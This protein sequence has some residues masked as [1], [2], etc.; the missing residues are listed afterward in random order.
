MSLKKIA[1]SGM[2]WTAAQQFSTQGVNFIVSIILA[3]ILLPDEFGLI[4]MIAVFIAIGS[5][6]YNSGLTQSLIR[7]KDPDQD[8]YSTVFWFNM[9]GSILLFLVMFCLAP[10]I[11]DFYNKEILKDIIRVYSLSFII[12]AFSAVQSTRLTKTFDFKAHL[13][14]SLPSTIVT[15]LTGIYM[16]YMGYGVWSLVFNNLAGA[17]CSSILF[18]IVSGWRPSF[19]FHKQKFRTHFKFGY[20]MTLSGLL[21]T[22]FDN[23]YIIVIG[24]FFSPSQVGYYTRADTLKQ[25]PVGNISTILNTVAYPLFAAIQDDDVRLKAVYKRIIKMV[26]FLVAPILVFMAVVAEPLF[27]FL[28]TEKW[29]PA[30]P[31]FQILC[32]AGI[33]YPVHAYNLNI[34]QVKGRSDLYLKLEM[35]K[36]V[37]V[38][39][40]ILIT[41]QFGIYGL[42]WGQIFLS[43]AAFFIN[44]YFT[45]KY[46]NY[47]S[48][49]QALDLIPTIGIAF[50][51]GAIMLLLDYFVISHL[52]DFLRIF[53]CSSIGTILYLGFAKIIK[54]DSL[55]EVIAI[56]KRK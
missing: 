3:R 2:V 20:N 25:F 47:T 49:E 29:L 48:W 30:V 50:F 13:K 18:W 1:L 5:M 6:L 7:T 38:I 46:L 54:E 11:A 23:V 43:I 34:L 12:N 26:I 37:I 16:A 41:I 32:V 21:S 9:A 53:I 39:V 40:V 33:L 45:G 56:I 42:L 51:A 22:V 8:D 31:Y 44:T 28:L 10:F 24:R 17:C 35:V 55:G 36:K 15:G 19:R 14:I 4:G 27:R 52:S